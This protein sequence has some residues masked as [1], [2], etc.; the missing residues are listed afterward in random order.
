MLNHL[1]TVVQLLFVMCTNDSLLLLVGK[2]CLVLSYKLR[3][4]LF[5]QGTKKNMCVTVSL[6]LLVP[7]VLHAYF[8]IDTFLG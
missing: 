8:V 4:F 6:R 1:K 3:N 7:R 2:L 5:K